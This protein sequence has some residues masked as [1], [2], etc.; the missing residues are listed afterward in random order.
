MFNIFLITKIFHVI[1]EYALEDSPVQYF[2]RLGR[3]F[4]ATHFFSLQDAYA[5]YSILFGTER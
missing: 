4:K 1:F 5:I 2:R 3:C